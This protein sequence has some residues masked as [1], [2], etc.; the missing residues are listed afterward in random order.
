M[1]TE[2]AVTQPISLKETME[3][4]TV[5][6]QSGFFSDAK[7]ASQAV[8]K[9]LAG[10]ELGFGPIASMTGV[11]II[12]GKPAIGA[13]LMAAKVKGSG[14]YNYRIVE[15]TDLACEIAFF[16]DGKEVGRS[17]FTMVDADRAGLKGKDN[18]KKFPRNMLFARAI[19]NGARWYCPDVFSG[20]SVYTPEEL[21]PDAPVNGDGDIIDVTPTPVPEPQAAAQTNGH[22]YPSVAAR[23]DAMLA[24][25]NERTNGYY[26]HLAHLL[27]AIQL[28]LGDPEWNWPEV[29]DD[30][31]WKASFNIALAHTKKEAG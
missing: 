17:R 9:V 29:S 27:N 4:G 20:V 6:A 30:M 28:E 24:A 22:S 3:L 7:Q 2:L 23:A 12:Q 21:D 19:S 10:R 25:V 31:T 5:L 16:E 14:R 26:K 15:N 1:T 11:N 18:W 8:V 13:N